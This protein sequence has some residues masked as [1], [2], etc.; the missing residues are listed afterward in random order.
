MTTI[1]LF[2]FV[3]FFA[4]KTLNECIYFQTFCNLLCVSINTT[5]RSSNF[6]FA[7]FTVSPV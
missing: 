7:C 4:V 3:L 6:L 1:E 2:F 5:V